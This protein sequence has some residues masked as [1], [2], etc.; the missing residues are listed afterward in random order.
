MTT[1]P[2]YL[3]ITQSKTN[4]PK[5]NKKLE[6]VVWL[7]SEIGTNKMSAAVQNNCD[8]VYWQAT[9]IKDNKVEI[10]ILIKD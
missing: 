9:K 8:W 7:F 5:Q 4:V 2:T 10:L 6:V 1:Y 3:I